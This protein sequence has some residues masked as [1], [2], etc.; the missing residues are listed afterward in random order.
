MSPTPPLSSRIVETFLRGHLTPLLMLLSLIAGFVALVVT[1]REE[2]P[3]IVVPV[4]DV[5]CSVPGASASE[6]EQVV[7][8][9]L[10]QILLE[11][12]GVEYVYSASQP[13]RAVVTVRFFVGEDREDSLIKLHNR[14]QMNADRIP[15]QVASWVVKPIEVDDVP[16]VAFT[17]WSERYGDHDLRRMVEEVERRIRTVPEVG[18]TEV[19]GGAPR[20]L[21]ILLDPEALAA[22]QLGVGDLARAVRGAA[23]GAAAGTMVRD[24][25]IVVSGGTLV[26]RAADLDHLVV[27]TFRD[28]PVLLRDV[29]R[30]VDGP[31]ELSSYTRIGFGPAAGDD[32]PEALRDPARDYAA[33]TLGVA[34]RKGANA[35]HV[36]ATLRERVAA[37]RAEILPDELHLQVTRDY[38]HTADRKVDELIESLLV[39]I[40]MV[41]ALLAMLLGWREALIVA[42]AVPLTFALT[43]AVNY[44]A[45]YS[46]NRVTM[47]A[48]ILAL[49]LVVDDPIVDVENIH[50]HLQRGSKDTFRAVLDA[51]NEVRPPIIQ[52]TLAVIVSFLPMF[53]ITGMMGPYMAPMALNV[54]LAMT[55][56]LLVA[57]MVTPWLSLH[58]LKRHDGNE[59]G[60][61][62]RPAAARDRRSLYARIMTG[63]LGSRRAQLAALA[64]TAV[65]FVLAGSLGLTR[66]V[67]L[68]MLPFDNKNELQVV[69][70]LPEGTA[71][72]QTEAAVAEMAAVVR[73]FAEVRDVST[74]VG[75]ASPMDFNGMVRQYYLRRG[76]H[77][78]DLR[79]NV[80]DKLA[81]SQQSHDLAIR[82]RAAL[83]PLARAHRARCKIVESPPG[84]PVVATLTAEVYGTEHTPYADIQAAARSVAARLAR[85]PGVVDLDTTIL[86]DQPQRVF[87]LDRAKAAL[88]GIRDA[89]VADLLRVATDG[90]TVTT[91]HTTRDVQPLAA[92]LHIERS[93]RSSTH[94]LLALPIPTVSGASITLAEVGRFREQSRDQTIYRKNTR[95]VVYVFSEIAGRPPADVILDVTADRVPAGASPGAER[96]I[97]VA[98]RT[99]LPSGGGLP[100]QVPAGIDVHWAGEGEWK[101]TLDAFRDLGLAFF[102]AC[103]GIYLLLVH[104]TRS[105]LMPLILMLAIPFTVLGILPGFWLLNALTAGVVEG[106]PTPVFFTATGMI[107]MIA[108]AGIAVR[109]SILLIEFVRRAEERGES[110]ADAVVQAGAARFRPILL[111]A[112]T[113]MLAALPI[114]IDPIFSGLAWALIF[115]L[116]VSSAFTL[117]FVPLI[118]AMV[119]G[120]SARSP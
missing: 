117:V 10:E 33:V 94:A 70:D 58:L 11:I 93:R 79:I 66:R 103:F 50:R 83:A 21:R 43:L 67:P 107:G 63:L 82:V 80:V 57:F 27:G 52:A 87:E 100:W 34:K 114:T 68:K 8:A 59:P 25:E 1:P 44:L 71:L 111:T 24:G 102:A 89:D 86:A 97:P 47:F 19:L 26:D 91:V 112:G 40:I 108:L 38:G 42:A 74:Y 101:I 64:V 120:R 118:Y 15:P 54:P 4:A 76:G 92:E 56:S 77:L 98:R 16:I 2:E 31:A 49:G 113:A 9:R 81:R 28:T 65:L 60:D 115:G 84:P 88:H 85:E 110:T 51:V 104:E 20:T 7:A 6:V 109:N 119:Y 3:Q 23:Q 14:L 5:I 53:F 32:I 37:L 90:S 72:E 96:A 99:F 17:F 45:G 73:G 62:D 29:A 75:I 35:V 46:I 78:A 12:D 95:R 13:D 116:L 48:L 30:V 22:R 41:I 55:M 18:R 69:V 61:D 39:A 106:V 36:A 105:Y